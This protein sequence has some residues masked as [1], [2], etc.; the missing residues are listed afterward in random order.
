MILLI[1]NSDIQRDVTC[2][3]KIRYGIIELLLNGDKYL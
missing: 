3:I 2:Q 1:H